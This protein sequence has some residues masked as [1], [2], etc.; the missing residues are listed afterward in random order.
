MLQSESSASADAINGHDAPD[1]AR[2]FGGVSRLYGEVAL[3]RFEAARV[4]VIGIGGVGSWAVEALARTA[5]GHLT[6]I[7]LDH[8]AEGNTNRQLHALDGNYGKAKVDAMAERVRLIDPQCDVQTV[9]D[10]IEEA[11][12][13]ALLGPGFDYVIDAIDNTK[14]K[15]A[16]I[17][18]CVARGQKIITIGS[19]GGQI[20]PTRIRVDDLTRT[21]QDPLLAK[22]RQRLRQQYRFP[23]SLKTRFGV[24]AVSSDEPLRYPEAAACDV[25]DAGDM[26]SSNE[27][28]TAPAGLNC[29][30]FG[31]SVVVTATFGL[32]AASHV[33]SE[34]SAAASN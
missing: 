17:A 31:S 3:R 6:L 10:F 9:D 20:D 1:R 2:R 14:V 4:A 12:F 5:I 15:T 32:V 28:S 7:D 8:V 18:W 34:L 26:Q 33:L 25:D 27:R 13:D 11:N 30:G 29:A 21:I 23:R 19:A 16:L 24:A 22:V